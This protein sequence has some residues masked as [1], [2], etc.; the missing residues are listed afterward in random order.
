MSKWVGHSNLATTL[1]NLHTNESY[2]YLEMDRILANEK[3]NEKVAALDERR[4]AS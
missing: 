2:E 1:K 4:K 3:A